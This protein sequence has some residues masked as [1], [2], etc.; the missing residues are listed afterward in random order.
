VT[1]I[2]AKDVEPKLLAKLQ[3]GELDYVTAV[4][5]GLYCDLGEGIVD[6]KGFAAAIDEI[7]FEGWVVAEEDQVLVPGR[8]APFESNVR[9]RAFLAELLGLE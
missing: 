1:H 3:A 6:W 9:N 8:Q 2:H 7:D 5:Q 4:G